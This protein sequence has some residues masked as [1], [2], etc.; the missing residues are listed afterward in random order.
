M[1]IIR[2]SLESA[3]EGRYSGVDFTFP[4]SVDVPCDEQVAR[5]IFGFGEEDKSPALLRLG[6]IRPGVD[7]TE[8]KKRLD[9]VVFKKAEVKISAVKD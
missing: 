7:A 5:H 4:P 8:A 1:I 3:I 6:W 9:A 2:N